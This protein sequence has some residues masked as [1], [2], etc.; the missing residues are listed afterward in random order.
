MK[1]W[2]KKQFIFNPQSLKALGIGFLWAIGITAVLGIFGVN[3]PAIG[4]VV[5]IVVSY[6]YQRKFS[7][8]KSEQEK[9]PDRDAQITPLS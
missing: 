2:F 1:N 8:L 7:K 5:W 9:N 6:K 4:I 3:T